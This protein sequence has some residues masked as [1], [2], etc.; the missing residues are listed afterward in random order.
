MT[1]HYTQITRLKSCLVHRTSHI[2]LFLGLL[3]IFGFLNTASAQIGGLSTF[4]FLKNSP[5]AR[6]SAL[7][8]SQIALK[9]EDLAL[10]YTNPALLN[11]LMHKALSL[12]YESR[13]GG[14]TNSFVAGAFTVEKLKLTFSTGISY[15]DYGTF[16]QTDEFGT[17]Q[18]E[19]KANEYALHVG[20][21]R[22]LNERIFSGREPQIHRVAT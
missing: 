5:S 13:L 15:Q 19:F 3:S 14:S 6:I 16:K 1:T 22:Q 10:G 8:Q 17:L 4:S 20:A 21:G 18:G 11:P 2:V 7:S 9:D 12:N